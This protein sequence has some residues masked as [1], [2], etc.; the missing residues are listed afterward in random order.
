MPDYVNMS[1]LQ[2]EEALS[3]FC[4]KFQILETKYPEMQCRF[5]HDMDLVEIHVSYRQLLEE[6]TKKSNSKK[7][8]NILFMYFYGLELCDNDMKG[9][10]YEQLSKMDEYTHLIKLIVDESLN[11]SG[12]SYIHERDLS[13]LVESEI[14]K[15]KQK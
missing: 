14:D 4:R 10:A 8:K 5:N 1:K 13:R 3:V 15:K 2:K 6:I 12:N 7:L 9:F 11:Y